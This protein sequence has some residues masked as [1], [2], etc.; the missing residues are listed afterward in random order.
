MRC[1]GGFFQGVTGSPKSRDW[2]GPC[3]ESRAP[4]AAPSSRVRGS[5][6]TFWE[7]HLLKCSSAN[8]PKAASVDVASQRVWT[9]SRVPKRE[10]QTWGA[11]RTSLGTAPAWAGTWVAEPVLGNHRRKPLWPSDPSRQRAG[12]RSQEADASDRWHSVPSLV[13]HP[14]LW[15]CF[16][17]ARQ[18]EEDF[19]SNHSSW[20]WYFLQECVGVKQKFKVKREFLL[21]YKGMCRSLLHSP[22]PVCFP[23]SLLCSLGL[24]CRHTYVEVSWTHHH[25]LWPAL[26]PLELDKGQN[27]KIGSE[28]TSPPPKL[29]ESLFPSPREVNLWSLQF[30]RCVRAI[31]YLHERF[32]S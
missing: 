5:Y 32:N 1:G 16:P 19:S 25:Q 4:L 13:T 3:P 26:N 6:W 30:K 28:T 12:E 23:H 18:G 8:I 17:F 7:T 15:L 22:A 20:A 9:R 10:R 11:R 21:K 24:L 2:T 14:H 29:I 31:T 27:P